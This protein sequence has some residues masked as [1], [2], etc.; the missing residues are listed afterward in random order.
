V[1]LIANLRTLLLEL[2]NG[3]LFDLR[4]FEAR[5]K[6]FAFDEK[7]SFAMVCPASVLHA[8]KLIDVKNAIYICYDKCHN[9]DNKVRDYGLSSG[10]KICSC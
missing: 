6:R 10:C 2:G 7:M 3:F 5:K 8:P 1:I 9:N 4:L